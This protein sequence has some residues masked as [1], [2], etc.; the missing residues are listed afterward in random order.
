MLPFEYTPVPVPEYGYNEIG[1]GSGRIN[2]DVPGFGSTFGPDENGVV[3]KL[4][5]T[6]EVVAPANLIILG[7]RFCRYRSP[8]QDSSLEIGGSWGM[9]PTDGIEI[10]PGGISYQSFLTSPKAVKMHRTAFTRLFCDGHIE[11][12]SFRKPFIPTDDYMRRWN[13][14][15][16]PHRE[17]NE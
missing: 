15:N 3:R 5:R 16:K 1:A 10:T 17:W 11:T 13:L 12:E 4:V 8:Q 7:D 2:G 6:F 14:D 9:N